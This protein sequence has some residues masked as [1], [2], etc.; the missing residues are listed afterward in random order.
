MSEEKKRRR[1]KPILEEVQPV[2]QVEIEAPEEIEEEDDDGSGGF[3][4]KR[5]P[6]ILRVDGLDVDIPLTGIKLPTFTTGMIDRGDVTIELVNLPEIALNGYFRS[7]LMKPLPRRLKL[8]VVDVVGKPIE[9]WEM[10]AVPGA[11]GF[12]EL[13]VQDDAPWVTQVAFSVTE[14]KIE[15]P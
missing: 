5:V 14:I 13:D 10:T 6:W 3:V 7:W 12:A 1:R 8:Q 15:T 4:V 11:M 2:A 9:T